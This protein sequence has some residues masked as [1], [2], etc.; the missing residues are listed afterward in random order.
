MILIF[1][2]LALLIGT[3][4]FLPQSIAGSGKALITY[5]ITLAILLTAHIFMYKKKDLRF[6]LLI[7]ILL[8]LRIFFNLV[9]LPDRMA[10]TPQ[11]VEKVAAEKIYAITQ[12]SEL[13]MA[14]VS[15]AS[16]EFIYYMSTIRNEILRKEYG[17]F[18]AGTY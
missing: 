1:T 15:P 13:M 16:V 12:N 9:V 18:K 3:G 2:G 5:C 10:K 7:I 14:P 11:Y 6:E 17:E 4:Y 8:F